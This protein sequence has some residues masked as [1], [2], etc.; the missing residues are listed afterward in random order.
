ML[1]RRALAAA[2]ATAAGGASLA[3]LHALDRRDRRAVAQDPRRAALQPPRGGRAHAIEA[4]DGTRLHAEVFGEE[5]A[6]AVV[7]VH[8]WTCELRFWTQQIAALRDEHRVIAFDL[9]GHGRSEQ[10]PGG[11]WST[12]ALA[13]DLDTVLERLLRPGERALVAGHSLGAMTIAAWAD[14]HPGRVAERAAAVAMLNTGMGDLVSEALVLRTP[15]GT[16]LVRDAVGKLVLG[17]PLALP[18]RSSPLSR[19]AV[20]AVALGPG[21]TPA[22]IEFCERMI[23]T[24]NPRARGGFGATLSRLDLHDALAHLDVP[25]LVLAGGRDRLT[26]PRL[27]ERMA[28]ALPQAEAPVVVERS[29]HM[30]PIETPGEVND[31]LRRLA[32]R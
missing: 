7:L 4:R 9:R 31:Q 6:P 15:P 21:A 14:R 10:P 8:G 13:D 11:D 20:A 25:A 3:A 12:D 28:D 29:G 16:A 23:M 17:V 24:T 26:P 2:A 5:D 1:D 27:A 30:S 32:R 18:Q 22:E 19:R